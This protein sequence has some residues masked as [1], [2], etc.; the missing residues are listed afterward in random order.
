MLVSA[1]S[2]MDPLYVYISLLL[3][4][5]STIQSLVLI[6]IKDWIRKW[7]LTPVF[8]SGKSHGR[9]SLVGY[10]SWGCK[11]SDTTEQLHFHF[12]RLG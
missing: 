10:R 4:L 3:S 7:Q 8:L 11:E 12:Q 1:I 2:N 9:R 5:P 6:N